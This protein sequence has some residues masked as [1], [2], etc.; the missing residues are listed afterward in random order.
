MIP[1]LK[2][3]S[4]LL[5]VAAIHLLIQPYNRVM[6]LDVSLWSNLQPEL[7]VLVG[8]TVECCYC[9]SYPSIELAGIVKPIYSSWMTFP[10]QNFVIVSLPLTNDRFN[11]S[12]L[13]PSSITG[14]PFSNRQTLKWFQKSKLWHTLQEKYHL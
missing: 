5:S 12:T 10:F 14:T 3:F 13:H 7:L 2:H 9:Y 4:S 8:Q 1:I 11:F 6:C